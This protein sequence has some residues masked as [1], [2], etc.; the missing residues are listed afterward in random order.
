M[1]EAH[2]KQSSISSLLV[3][4]FASVGMLMILGGIISLWQLNFIRERAQYLYQTDKPARAV[5]RVHSDFLNFQ[6]ELLPLSNAQDAARFEVEGNRLLLAFSN[7]VEQATEA[8]RALPAG[9]QRDSE[10]SSLETVRA[11]F[12]GQVESLIG[13]A[14]SGDWV[15]VR[16]RLASRMPMIGELSESL[17]HDIDAIVEI[18]KQIGLEDIRQAQI[19]TNW[20]LGIAGISSLVLAALLGVAVTKRI[21]GR[22]EKLDVASRALARGQFQH[23]VVVGGN[24]EITRLSGAFNNMASRLRG[25]YEELQRSEAHFRALIENARDFIL[26]VD[27]DGTVRYA[28]PSM[29]REFAGGGSFIGKNILSLAEP[30]DADAVMALLTPVAPGVPQKSVEFRMR[31]ADGTLRT[32]ETHGNPLLRDSAIAGI[33]FNARDITERQGM[34]ERLRQA[35]RMEAIGTLSGGIAHD[36]NNLLTI[37]RGYAHQ[38]LESRPDAAK[39]RAQVERIDEAAERAAALTSQLLAFS[40]RQ[41][42]QPRVFDLNAL[43]TGLD[44]MLRRLIGEHIEMNTVVAEDSCLVQ[45]DTGQIEQVIMNLV[46]NARDAMPHGGKLTLETANL[47]LDEAYA[48]KH[49]GAHAGPYVMLA[50]SDTGVGMDAKTQ[51]R[52]FDPFFTTKG[53]GKGTGLGLSTAYGIV[54]QS[55]GHIWVYSEPDR[56]STFKVYLPQVVDAKG[57]TKIEKAPAV[58]PRGHETVLVVEDEP[59]LRELVEMMLI[60]RGYSILTVENPVQAEAF[61]KQYSGPIH[62]LLTDVVLPGISGRE[63]ARQVAAHRPDIKVLFTS[64]YTPDAIIHHGVLEAGLHFIQKPFTLETLTNKVRAVLNNEI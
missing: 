45:A 56:G 35:Q 55:G 42:L 14:K 26:L 43:T 29:E 18:E 50:I 19:R 41:V 10:R 5:L 32:L 9:T 3:L 16:L 8:V 37:I 25:L 51:A 30:A 1:P 54:K 38:L 6:R 17:V 2:P 20:T 15:G 36:F 12:A 62:L 48:A 57:P 31:S 58:E 40:R 11:L 22:L 46:I 4:S 53:L 64:G 28:S 24:D 52:I 34:E 33:V 47:E 23:Q 7:D 39:A 49:E 63:V 61:S 44:E 13:L 59:Q 60:S 27:A 21:A